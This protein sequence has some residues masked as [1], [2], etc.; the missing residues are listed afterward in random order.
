MDVGDEMVGMVK[1]NTKG[2]FKDTIEKLT[3]Y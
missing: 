2:L 3:N 1:T